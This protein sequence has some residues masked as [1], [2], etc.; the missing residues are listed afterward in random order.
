M[1]E[2]QNG[3][4]ILTTLDLVGDQALKGRSALGDLLESD[5]PHGGET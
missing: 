5:S 2:D 4:A 1:V 3:I